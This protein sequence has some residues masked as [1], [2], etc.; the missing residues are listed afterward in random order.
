[1]VD[2]PAR[3]LPEE[4]VTRVSGRKIVDTD[5][6]ATCSFTRGRFLCTSRGFGA[7]GSGAVRCTAATAAVG[8]WTV[9]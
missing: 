6:G 3:V 2:Q 5:R 8:G 7:S 4:P 1:M 9:R